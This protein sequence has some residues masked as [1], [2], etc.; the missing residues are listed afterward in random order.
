MPH[1]EAGLFSEGSY[2]RGVVDAIVQAVHWSTATIAVDSWESR[3]VVSSLCGRAT[4]SA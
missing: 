2:Q 3:N 1:K 4:T